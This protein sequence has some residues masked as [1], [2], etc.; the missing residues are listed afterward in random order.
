MSRLR[1]CSR[2]NFFRLLEVIENRR[3]NCTAPAQVKWCAEARQGR[4]RNRVAQHFRQVTSKQAQSSKSKAQ[5]KLQTTKFRNHLGRPTFLPST[6]LQSG[7]GSSAADRT[8]STVSASTKRS[9]VAHL[10][11]HVG[12]VFF[13][14][15][16]DDD[17]FDARALSREGFFFEAA[18]GQDE[19][20]QGDFAGHSD[21]G[22]HR[23]L[24][25]KG[26]DGGDHN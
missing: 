12:Q 25:E 26:G 4:S 24:A 21:V 20:A 22:A 17:S 8:S 1:S 5:N 16:R 9:L 7:F 15:F 6:A 19:A 23:P 14:H 13:V 11:G 2:L 18:D 10:G 3:D